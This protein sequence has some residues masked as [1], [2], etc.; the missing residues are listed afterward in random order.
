MFLCS[1]TIQY[2]E[3]KS[4]VVLGSTQTSKKTGNSVCTRV[5]HRRE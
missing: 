1:K 3:R 5:T 2:L 4:T